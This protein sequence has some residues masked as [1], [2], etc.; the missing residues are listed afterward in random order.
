MKKLTIVFF[1]LSVLLSACQADQNLGPTAVPTEAQP[2]AAM[3]P[4]PSA[5][6]PSPNATATLAEQLVTQATDLIGVWQL[7]SNPDQPNPDYWLFRENGTYT[8]AS[9]LD[10]SKP[11]VSGKFWFENGIFYTSDD[12]CPTPGKYKTQIAKPAGQTKKLNF[13]LVADNCQER[14]KEFPAALVT[15]F[16]PLQP[17]KTPTPTLSISPTSTPTPIALT[18]SKDI[19]YT[20][21]RKLDVYA[22]AAPG[23]WPVVVVYHGGSLTKTSVAGLSRAIAGRGAVVFTPT[24]RSSEPPLE[25][26]KSGA[27]GQG[28]EDAACA[29]RTARA[30]APEFGG[31]PSRIVVVGHSAGGVAAAI[32]T[33]NGDGFK[34][35]CLV[36][37]GSASADA[38]V[39]LEGAYNLP[40]YVQKS[41]YEMATP[42]VWALISAYTYVDR[43]PIRK[44]VGFQIVVGSTEELI[45]DG[46]A[47]FEALKA[48]GYS[49]VFTEFPGV[50][51]MSIASSK[52]EIIRIIMGAV[53]PVIP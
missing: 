30:K 35:D 6:L 9:N 1:I 48:A 11:I 52:E 26:V 40:L 19:P 10:G 32:M 38:M 8:I 31:N 3:P 24:W 15:W 27:I 51:H 47:F 46:K 36:N 33:L 45:A 5:T 34:G 12:F 21:E 39:G 42:E 53:Y 23:P 22:P 43:Q 44:E 25:A 37:E 4:A 2:P 14:V 18:T 16:Q 49:P 29:I 7:I 41:I 50:D 28:F 20:S 13:T 17:T